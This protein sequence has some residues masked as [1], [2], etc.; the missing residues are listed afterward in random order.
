M[1]DVCDRVSSCQWFRGYATEPLGASAS[2]L[3][4]EVIEG[5]RVDERFAIPSP[6]PGLRLVQRNVGHVNH[7][8]P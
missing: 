8:P 1:S 5:R 3:L 4:R 7:A 6:R 2:H